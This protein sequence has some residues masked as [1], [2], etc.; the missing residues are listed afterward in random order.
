VVS[1]KII[2]Q[3]IIGYDC[4]NLNRLSCVAVL[5]IVREGGSVSN[6]KINASLKAMFWKC[7]D[8]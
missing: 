7:I 6:Q 2:K 3:A 1:R 4:S 5:S 8:E